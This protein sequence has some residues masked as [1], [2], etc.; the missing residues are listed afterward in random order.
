[1]STRPTLPDDSAKRRLA[2]ILGVRPPKLSGQMMPRGCKK[3]PVT[4]AQRQALAD[5]SGPSN[6]YNRPVGSLDYHNNS[7]PTLHLFGGEELEYFPSG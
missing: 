3:K 1:V 6:V 4:A 5:S 7:T 2:K